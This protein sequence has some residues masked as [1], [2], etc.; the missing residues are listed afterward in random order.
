MTWLPA[1]ARTIRRV[2]IEDDVPVSVD[3]SSLLRSS[4]KADPRRFHFWR[5]AA[6]EPCASI[7]RPGLAL[8]LRIGA[9]GPCAF[10]DDLRRLWN[11]APLEEEST[12]WLAAQR[13]FRCRSGTHRAGRLDC[14]PTGE[15]PKARADVRRSPSEIA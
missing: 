13:S 12:L 1:F 11:L 14:R 7:S 4:T 15:V 9:A 2:E 3:C 5:E 10:P 6:S 8:L